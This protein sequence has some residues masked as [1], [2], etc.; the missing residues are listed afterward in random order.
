MEDKDWLEHEYKNTFVGI[1]HNPID[2][3][4]VSND[5]LDCPFSVEYIVQSMR[6]Y[7]DPSL[8]I[9]VVCPVDPAGTVGQDGKVD[10]TREF[11]VVQK[12]KC[13]KAFQKLDKTGEFRKL[14]GHAHRTNCLLR[15]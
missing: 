5:M 4:S 2:D 12:V 6:K 1:C 8:S 11:Y 14:S 7:Y 13:F 9:L 10:V 15:S 3:I